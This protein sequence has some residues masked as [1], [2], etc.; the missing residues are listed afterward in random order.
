MRPP[1]FIKEPGDKSF[2]L[3]QDRP[4]NRT[5]PGT[6][7]PKAIGAPGN[8][9]EPVR[10]LPGGK[11]PG[12]YPF[13]RK[14]PD[15]ADRTGSARLNF[16]HQS[17]PVSPMVSIRR[18]TARLVHRTKKEVVPKIEEGQ[19]NYHQPQ[20]HTRL[21]TQPGGEG[22]AGRSR[23]RGICSRSPCRHSTGGEGHAGRSR[24][25]GICSRSPAPRGAEGSPSAGKPDAFG[26]SRSSP[27]APSSLPRIRPFRRTAV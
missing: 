12:L 6:I 10:G 9:H 7:P 2:P 27:P 11:G 21:P 8:I 13:P 3:T 17:R 15:G 19:P 20:N 1:G 23:C 4:A 16:S 5:D 24:C 26:P 25:R 18:G 22:H 14:Q